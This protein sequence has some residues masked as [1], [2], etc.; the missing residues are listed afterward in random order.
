[1]YTWDFKVT[2]KVEVEN[3]ASGLC[4]KN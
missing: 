1:V 4:T 2:V 3:Y